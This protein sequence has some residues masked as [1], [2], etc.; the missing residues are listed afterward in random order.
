[1]RRPTSL[2]YLFLFEKSRTSYECVFCKFG[3]LTEKRF[4]LY[5]RR[6]EK[7]RTEMLEL[8]WIKC[9]AQKAMEYL[10]IF[11]SIFQISMLKKSSAY[12]HKKK[13]KITISRIKSDLLFFHKQIIYCTVLVSIFCFSKNVI[14]L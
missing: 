9:A 8:Y 14:P 2:F 7:S 1:M 12:D 4:I 3:V 10:T 13:P 11:I 5:R 6:R